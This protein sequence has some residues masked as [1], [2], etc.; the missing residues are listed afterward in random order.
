ME[1]SPGDRAVYLQGRS[2]IVTR[3]EMRQSGWQ[4]GLPQASLI[5]RREEKGPHEAG[6]CSAAI[7]PMRVKLSRSLLSLDEFVLCKMWKQFLEIIIH[8]KYMSREYNFMHSLT[9]DV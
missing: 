1:A 4:V 7:R 9:E 5:Q 2:V 3:W 8:K 6:Q